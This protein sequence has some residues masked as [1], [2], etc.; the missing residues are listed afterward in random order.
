MRVVFD[1]VVFV[2]GLINP[3][4]RWGELL[5]EHADRYVLILSPA[6]AEEILSVLRRPELTRKFRSL[7]NIGV[8]DVLTL[9]AQADVVQPAETLAICHDPN[10]DKFLAAAVA[11]NADY[12]VSEDAD[13]LVLGE[14]QGIPIVTASAFLRI[15]QENNER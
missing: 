12:L 14:N 13:L 2:R 6:I 11:G 9:L 4:G 3:H 10:D 5:F 15:L 7:S 8:A 1:T